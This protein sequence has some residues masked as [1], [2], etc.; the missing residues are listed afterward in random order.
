VKRAEVWW[1]DMAEPRGS[2]PAHRRPVIIVQDDL[3]TAS[4]LGTVMVVPLTTNLDRAKAIGNVLLRNSETGL[5]RDSVALVCQIATLDKVFLDE[6]VG[7]IS[8]RATA[9]IDLGLRLSLGLR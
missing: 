2:E 9:A 1:A 5:K 8:R 3:L 4:R 7:S 6:R